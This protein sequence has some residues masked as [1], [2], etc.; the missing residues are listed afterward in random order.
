MIMQNFT[1]KHWEEWEQGDAAASA[2]TAM[3]CHGV[4]CIWEDSAAD[5]ISKVT[6]SMLVPKI[7]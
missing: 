2:Q 6:L 7:T 1:K 3:G 4:L 5:V